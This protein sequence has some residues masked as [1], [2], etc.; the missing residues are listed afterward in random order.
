MIVNDL[1]PAEY[2]AVLRQD[3]TSFADRCFSDLN[4]QAELTMNWHLERRLAKSGSHMT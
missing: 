2:H 3:F 1:T 4:P